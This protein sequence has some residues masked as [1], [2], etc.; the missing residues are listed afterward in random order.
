MSHTFH[1]LSKEL[2]EPYFRWVLKETSRAISLF[3]GSDQLTMFLKAFHTALK[4]NPSVGASTDSNRVLWYHNYRSCMPNVFG[5][6]AYYYIALEK[7]VHVLTAKSGQINFDVDMISNEVEKAENEHVQWVNV[8]FYDTQRSH[9]PPTLRL[10]GDTTAVPLTEAQIADYTTVTLTCIQVRK[11][12]VHSLGDFVLAQVDDSFKKITIDMRLHGAVR[13][14]PFF[15]IVCGDYEVEGLAVEW[16]PYRV[17]ERHNFAMYSGAATNR[18]FAKPDET[19][20][21]FHGWEK[22][23]NP[24]NLLSFFGYNMLTPAEILH[25]YPDVYLQIPWE[26]KDNADRDWNDPKGVYE[27]MLAS[28]PASECGDDNDCSQNSVGSKRSYAPTPKSTPNQRQKTEEEDRTT[29]PASS[30]VKSA[31]EISHLDSSKNNEDV[32]QVHMQ[33]QTRPKTCASYL[34]RRCLM[35]PHRRSARCLRLRITTTTPTASTA[36]TTAPHLTNRTAPHLANRAK[37]SWT[38]KTN[39]LAMRRASCTNAR[40]S[41]TGSSAA[42]LSRGTSRCASPANR[43]TR[44][45]R[46]HCSPRARHRPQ[47]HQ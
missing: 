13:K 11:D 2:L 16:P 46:R 30:Q 27:D 25:K 1:A 10:E 6:D 21:G 38:W 36:K 9:W 12:Y 20:D 19:R 22:D 40:I 47:H 3:A 29:S 43:G 8:S 4:T 45:L 28:Q 41:L 33:C 37:T 7:V 26:M 14:V 31:R 18:N 42:K 39:M 44:A 32:E 15:E 17:L 5:G 24:I 23:Y 34:A 35:C